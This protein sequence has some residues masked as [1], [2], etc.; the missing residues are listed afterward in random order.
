MVVLTRARS[1]GAAQERGPRS[2]RNQE[3]TAQQQSTSGEAGW[4]ELAQGNAIS[5]NSHPI[6]QAGA[7]LAESGMRWSKLLELSGMYHCY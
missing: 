1:R 5:W 2:S 6:Q 3:S 4:M 7:L